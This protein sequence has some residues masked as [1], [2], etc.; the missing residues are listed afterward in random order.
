[1]KLFT[2]GFALPSVRVSPGLSSGGGVTTIDVRYTY[3]ATVVKCLAYVGDS[4]AASAPV[5]F[6]S[7]VPP[8]PHC[9]SPLD[10]VREF[11][12]CMGPW[13]GDI[14][15]PLGGQLVITVSRT[16]G[17][18]TTFLQELRVP[19]VGQLLAVVAP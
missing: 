8:S 12:E 5:P 11:F 18:Q 13:V 10:D 17:G 14:R 1:M 7:P 15:V 19:L 2:A 9:T 16:E 6:A 4:C 3:D